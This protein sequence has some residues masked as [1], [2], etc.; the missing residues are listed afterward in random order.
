MLS[1]DIPIIKSI[2]N[3]PCWITIPENDRKIKS[4][5]LWRKKRVRLFLIIASSFINLI[6]ASCRFFLYGNRLNQNFKDL[7]ED[8]CIDRTT[9]VIICIL[10]LKNPNSWVAISLC[11]SILRISCPLWTYSQGYE[12]NQWGYLSFVFKIFFQLFLFF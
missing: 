12:H 8:K 4:N 5:M 2:V 3:K 7:T 1:K 6:I 9:Y 11:S 10:L